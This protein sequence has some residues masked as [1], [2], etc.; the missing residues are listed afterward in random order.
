MASLIFAGGA[1][2]AAVS[3]ATVVGSRVGGR[4]WR[5]VKVAG[6]VAP[7]TAMIAGAALSAA[8]GG[9]PS[10]LT[11]ADAAWR[12]LLGAVVPLL[13]AFAPPAALLV[14]SGGAVVGAAAGGP[15][16]VY[17]GVATGGVLAAVLA[18]WSPRGLRAGIGAALAGATLRLSW[19]AAPR[20]TAA[21][22]AA[23]V[24]CVCVPGLLALPARWRRRAVAVGGAA[25][26]AGVAFGALAVFGAA[27]AR[28][29]VESGVRAVRAA[30]DAAARGDIAGARAA[31]GD[32]GRAFGA[33]GRT[34]DGW[35]VAPGLALPAA[36]PNVRALRNGVRA[37]RRVAVAGSD[38]AASADPATLRWTD[39]RVPI[40]RL[41]ALEPAVGHA[42]SVTAEADAELRTGRSP[43][44]LAPVS[45][46]LDELG[47]RI[48]RARNDAE[49]LLSAL[50][51]GPGLL[52]RDG[53]KRYF[54]AIETPSE[55]RASGGFIGNYGELTASDGH[56]RLDKIGRTA[57]LNTGGHPESRALHAPPDY[58]ARYSRFDPAVTWQN[59]TMS[60]DFP[61][62]AQVI[63]GLYPQS[64]GRP[65][66]G[67]IGVDPYGLAALLRITGPVSVEP[68]PEPITA[69]NASHVLLYDQYVRLGDSSVR[70]DFLGR[71][72]QTVWQRFLGTSA[73]LADLAKA[74]GPAAAGRHLA[75]A[76][77]DAGQEAGLRQL[78]LA[79]AMAPVA[80]D[81]LQLVTQ[82][83][84]GNKID[85][86]L[87]RELDY[88]VSLGS[89]GM[90]SAD[91][92]VTLTNN[93]PSSGL[94][95]YLIGNA[96]QPPL[97]MGTNRL[98]VSLYSPWNL[99]GATLDGQQQ[100]MES[101]NEQGRFVYSAFVEIPPGATRTLVVH[102]RGRVGLGD[103]YRL[104][105]QRQPTVVT[106]N[107]AVAVSRAGDGWGR[108][109]W[110]C[111][112]PGPAAASGTPLDLEV[113][114][115]R[116]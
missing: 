65:V 99:T 80:G 73:S 37:G 77:T 7:G 58:V 8:A 91:A 66:D 97:P 45:G 82:N 59:V 13:A 71:V 22:A 83:A 113:R 106:D 27:L 16:V 61:T 41:P 60:P 110:S 84:S 72:T 20:A 21:V 95:A 33:A 54:L 25:G 68:W 40:E 98:Y 44:V 85:W 57:D 111:E 108:R 78:G 15:G 70:A 103:G 19:P 100:L 62:V 74:L 90:L 32:A 4:R 5:P 26:G 101:Q 31:T 29:H 56:M 67:V 48:A 52:G 75:V 38:L 115:G 104:D 79:G 36:G 43:W 49:H 12:I 3:L 42:V 50:R 9:H 94:D 35:W 114:C 102:L 51:I 23:V 17:A 34:T 47:T 81:Y 1:A 76:T 6:W 14:A 2:F 24:A 116:P 53:A 86:F 87:R 107:V 39:G 92:T 46:R 89:S 63:E 30:V 109:R 28:P 105:L 64:G 96:V 69:D 18:R 10:G 55:A 112:G 93:A 88:R 11:A